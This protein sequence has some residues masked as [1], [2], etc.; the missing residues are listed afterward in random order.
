M[1]KEDLIKHQFK[2]GKTGNPDGRPKGSLSMTKLLRVYLETKDPKTGKYIKDIV[3]EAFVKRAV[4]KSDVLMKEILDR[5]D[6]KVVNKNELSG[7]DGGPLQ[8]TGV[9]ISIRK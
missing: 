8:I 6:G 7:K 3:N 4:A 2:K 9:E 5:V 1:S